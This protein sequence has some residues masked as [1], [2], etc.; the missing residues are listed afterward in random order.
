M[1]TEDGSKS[2]DWLLAHSHDGTPITPE[3]AG[4]VH[5]RPGLLSVEI[6][7]VK[8]IEILRADKPGFWDTRACHSKGAPWTELRYG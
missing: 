7:E 5:H 6:V 1:A 4:P 3:H 8:R 2:A